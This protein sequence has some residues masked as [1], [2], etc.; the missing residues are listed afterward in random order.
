MLTT[1]CMVAEAPKDESPAAAC[2]VAAWA[3]WAAWAWTCKSALPGGN[4]RLDL[5]HGKGHLGWPFFL[6]RGG[7]HIPGPQTTAA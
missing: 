3:A 7:H 1:E 2:P 6:G 4:A 5:C